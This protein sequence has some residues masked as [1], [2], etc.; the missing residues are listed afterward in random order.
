[1]AAVFPPAAVH[2]EAA[3]SESRASGDG[4]WLGRVVRLEQTPAGV[5]VRTAEPEVA[6]D[7]TGDRAAALELTPGLAVRLRVDPAEVRLLAPLDSAGDQDQAPP[8]R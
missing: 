2:L 1:M 3:G 6:I 5:R 8:A 4:E 7:L